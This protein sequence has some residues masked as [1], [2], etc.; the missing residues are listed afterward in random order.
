VVSWNL[1]SS[2]RACG[3]RL[4][5]AAAA[6]FALLAI[7]MPAATAAPATD[8]QGYVDSTAR[9]T[10]PDTVVAF[11]STAT[12]RMAI[13][14][15][16]GGQ[17]EYRGVRVSDGATLTVPASQSGNG[18]VADNDGNT[19]TLTSKSLVVSAGGKVIR[20]EPMVD[21]HTSGTGAAPAGTP[22]PASP[23]SPTSPTSRTSPG[24]S[25]GTSAPTP[26]PTPTPTTPLPPPLPAEVG[27]GAH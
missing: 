17:Y 15:T 25:P 22:G 27:G 12:S 3:C 16:A 24:T 14:K 2:H 20:E 19:Y 1:M 7:G 21:F 13:C 18:Y 8:G 10:P 9:C 4:I 23:T 6:W 11:G 5:V 26:T